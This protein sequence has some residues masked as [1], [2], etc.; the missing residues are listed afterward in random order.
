MA[1]IW[2]INELSLAGTLNPAL[3]DL[4]KIC[5]LLQVELDTNV[6]IIECKSLEEFHTL[7][8]KPYSIAAVY[9]KGVI[10][11]QPFTILRSKGLL[12]EILTHELLHHVLS[13]NFDLPA[14]MQE[15]LILYLTGVKPENLGGHHKYY[16]LRFLREVHH[17]EIY[18]LVDRYRRIPVDQS[19]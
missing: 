17:E 9:S 15:G 16:L 12:E 5:H 10:W 4:K 13:L 7:T 3:A 6:L 8:G 2:T 18:S 11:T 19:R 14:W 1:K